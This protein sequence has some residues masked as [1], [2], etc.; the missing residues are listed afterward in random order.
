MLMVRLTNSP[1]VIKPV[2]L[3]TIQTNARG[4]TYTMEDAMLEP[5]KVHPLYQ[6]VSQYVG[7]VMRNV[8]PVVRLGG[9]GLIV[10][11]LKDSFMKV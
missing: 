2:P 7:R 8:I 4:A 1:S 10:V 6:M 3:I 5:G 11:L 9:L